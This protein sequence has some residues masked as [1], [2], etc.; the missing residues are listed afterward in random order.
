MLT[1][2]E[3]VLILKGADLLKDVGPRHLL[4]LAEAATEIE[5]VKG[6]HIYAEED[7]ADAL[8]MVVE[9]RVKLAEG[10]RPMS[11]VGAGEAFGT[12]SLVDESAR[13]HRAEC[14]ESGLMLALHREEF[15][16]VAAGD[17]TLLQQIIRVLAKR[18]R[19][20]AA[21]RPPE[22]ARVEGEGIEKPEAVV[23][24]EAGGSGAG[25]GAPGTILPA[26]GPALTA[27]ALGHSGSGPAPPA[28]PHSSDDS[29][30]AGPAAAGQARRGKP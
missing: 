4:S 11:E 17:L 25:A 21:E 26:S 6:D 8:Y 13:G 24:A 28:P 2:V 27:A 29:G 7:P 1:P 14:L 30:D 22:D 12:W 10:D 18:L 20:V 16:D 5:M 23:E 19:A 9:G 15:Y 3:R